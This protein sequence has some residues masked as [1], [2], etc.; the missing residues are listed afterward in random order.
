MKN[1]EK[2]AILCHIFSDYSCFCDLTATF[3]R[4]VMQM[5]C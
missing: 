3:Y 4:L 1:G 5:L 2:I